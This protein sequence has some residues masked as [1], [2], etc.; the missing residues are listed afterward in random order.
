MA[1]VGFSTGDFENPSLSLNNRVKFCDY[2]GEA[3][4]L[5]FE[6]PKDLFDFRLT[7]NMI[8]EIMEHKY[9][10]IHAPFKNIK[11]KSD[12]NTDIILKKLKYLCKKLPIKGIVIH[13]NVIVDFLKLD[14]SGLPFLIENMDKTKSIG[15]HPSHFSEYVKKYKFN[16]VFDV[17][18]AF[19]HD[20][21]MKLGKEII[22]V[23]GTRL[24]HMHVSG[25]NKRHNHYP[26]FISDNKKNIT[27]ILN[28][29]IPVPKILEGFLVIDFRNIAIDE[30]KFIESFEK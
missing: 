30:I 14:E 10:T 26:T 18:H 8:K 4:E 2:L 28:M 3:L 25:C 22:K 12:K 6:T 23:M 17:Q 15:T 13:P 20:P 11:Y 19:E 24:Q 27:K 7:S 29:K 1:Y 16:F 9:V 5:L 21:S